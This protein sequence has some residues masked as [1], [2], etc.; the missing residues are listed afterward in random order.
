MITMLVV[1]VLLVLVVVDDT[2]HEVMQAAGA[3][4]FDTLKVVALLG[5][6]TAVA[7]P[8]QYSPPAPIAKLTA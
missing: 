2:L 3:P 4:S 8:P 5:F 1:V 6:G 7:V